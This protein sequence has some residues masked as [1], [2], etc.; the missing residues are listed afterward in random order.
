VADE[1]VEPVDDVEGTVRPELH[2]YRTEVRVCRLQQRLDLDADEARA[3]L[4]G[5]VLLDALEPDG[6]VEKEVALRRLREV[7]AADELAAGGRAAA[8]SA[9]T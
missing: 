5:A 1:R 9:S 8:P 3:V 2:R 4:D 7:A 6:V